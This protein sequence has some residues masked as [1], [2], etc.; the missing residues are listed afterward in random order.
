MAAFRQW[1]VGSPSSLSTNLPR[2]LVLDGGVSTHL[3]HL[4]GPFQHRELWSSSLLVPDAG[5]S[6][7]QTLLQGHLDWLQAG[8]NVISTVTYQCHYQQEYWPEKAGVADEKAMDEM[9]RKG[10]E[11]ATT[12]VSQHQSSSSARRPQ[13][14]LASSGCYGAALANGAEYTG[15]YG[16]ASL[17]DLEAFHLHKLIQISKSR[18]D[19]IALETVPSIVECQALRNVLTS[20]TDLWRDMACYVSLACRN[21]RELNDGTPITQALHLFRDI[22]IG[23]GF[24]CCDV[25][26]LR[27]GLLQTL[28][29]EILETKSQR[30]IVFYPN[31]GEA[32]NAAKESWE[33]GTGCRDGR[34]MAQELLECI[35]LV[36]NLCPKDNPPPRMLVGGCCRTTPSAV[37]HLVKLVDQH[38][39]AA[40]K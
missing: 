30:A 37:Q 33:E 6:K 25:A 24:N 28:V 9:W 32:W 31:S 1:M 4:A 7:E 20:R 15:E 38:L 14:V 17:A 26:H 36:E 22:P 10:I 40:N 29:K 21:H 35:H 2:I 3:E 34:K 19:G 39:G 5:N 13:F 16:T 18:P 12:A 27:N 23:I 11:I 8:A